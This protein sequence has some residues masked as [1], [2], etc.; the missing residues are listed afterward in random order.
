[1]TLIYQGDNIKLTVSYN[2]I[3]LAKA[4]SIMRGQALNVGNKLNLVNLEFKRY[5]CS[6]GVCLVRN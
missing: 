5:A 6:Q 4:V 3:E 2:N 1:M